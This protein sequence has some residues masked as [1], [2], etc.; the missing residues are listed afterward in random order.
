MMKI[1]L[2]PL[3]LVRKTAFSTHVTCKIIKSLIDHKD[4]GVFGG[5]RRKCVNV[6]TRGSI[7][8]ANTTHI[9]IGIGV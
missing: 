7:S 8:I 4:P 6:F 3:I 9:V 1:A 2:N 5:V